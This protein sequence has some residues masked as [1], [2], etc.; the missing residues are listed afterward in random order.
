MEMMNELLEKYFRG[1]TSLAEEK[2]LKQYF[3]TGEVTAE[4]EIYR[5]L[6]EEFELELNETAIAPLKI[7]IPKQKKIKHVW[8]RTFALTAIAATLLLLLWIRMPD[9]TDNYA[10]I[11]GNRIN[12]SEFAERYTQKKLNKVNSMLARSMKPIQSLDKV[13]DNLQPLQSVSD[14]K[15]KMNEIQNKL[16]FK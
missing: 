9:S 2:E 11:G 10:I 12:N 8:I 7:I 1:E 15:D 13:R 5:A 6:F 14:M 4:H 16:Q 3:S